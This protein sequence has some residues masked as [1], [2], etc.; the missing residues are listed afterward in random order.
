MSARISPE[1]L[2]TLFLFEQLEP[3]RLAWLAER[4]AVRE[5]PSGHRIYGEGESGTCFFVL[6]SGTMS[7]TRAVRGGGEVE[8]TRSDHRGTYFGGVMGLL[9]ED[10][11]EPPY[12]NSGHAI[13]DVTVFELSCADFR[14]FMERWYP[15]ALHLVAGVYGTMRT[16]QA[17]VAERERLVA[18]GSV[19]AGLTHELNNPAAATQRAVTALREETGILRQKLAYLA[20]SRLNPAVLRE[21][22]SV[23]DAAVK[24]MAAAPKLSPL[25]FSDREDEM[26]DWLEE[27]GVDNAVD[28]APGLVAA[29]L[30]RGW[31]E[32]T[33]EAVGDA[34]PKAIGWLAHTVEIESLLTEIGD[35][36]NRISNLIASAKQYSQMDRA[37]QQRVDVTELLDSTLAI[38]RHKVGPGISVVTDY[39][40]DAPQIEVY[41]AELNQVW[42]NLIHN[43]IDAMD[44]SGTLTVRTVAE[45]DALLVEIGDTGSGVP[46]EIQDRIFEPFFTTKPVGHGTGLGLDIA[47]RIVVDRHGG[48]LQVHSVPG[49]TRFQ[50]RIPLRPPAIADSGDNNSSGG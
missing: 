32:A 23:Q 2:G 30:D 42:T 5:Y 41:A 9:T 43:A 44:G 29:G 49:D 47:W 35:A 12:T 19:T 13:T 14:R 36:A 7:L 4:G 38:M 18:L 40:P 34:L 6:L 50:T 16:S 37:P 17:R 28:Y 31:A 1:E 3:E 45:P 22:V 27:H 15:I 39:D 21:L 24:G 10:F 48:D 11:Q 20:E 33:S 8:V 26:I 46:Q 25:E